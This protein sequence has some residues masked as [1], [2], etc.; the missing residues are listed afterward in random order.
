MWLWNH[1]DLEFSMVSDKPG[2]IMREMLR[3]LLLQSTGK[4]R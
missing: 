3:D 2:L 1:V 4:R